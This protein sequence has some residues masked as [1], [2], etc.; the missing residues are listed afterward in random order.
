M[1]DMELEMNRDLA[2][3]IIMDNI[4][5]LTKQYSTTQDKEE[6]LKL[7]QKLDLLNKIK[8]ELYLANEEIINKVIIKREKGML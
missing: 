2:L 1:N 3:E 4:A 8:E 5:L 6:C 7:K